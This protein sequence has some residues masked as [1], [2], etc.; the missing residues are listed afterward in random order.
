MRRSAGLTL[1][2]VALSTGVLALATL[3]FASGMASAITLDGQSRERAWARTVAQKQL[4]TLASLPAKDVVAQDA[5]P[6]D[7]AVGFDLN[8]D[9]V[10]GAGELLVPAPPP[11]ES[12][13]RA[14]AGRVTADF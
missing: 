8:G 10:L 13:P 11:G 9:G 3:T 5:Q 6:R 2:E 4:E 14:Q 1:I 12:P 7:F